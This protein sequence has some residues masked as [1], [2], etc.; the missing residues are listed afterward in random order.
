MSVDSPDEILALLIQA[1]GASEVRA[2]LKRSRPPHRP[3][4][5]GIDDGAALAHMFFLIF[6]GQA[7][8]RTKAARLSTHL[9]TGNSTESTIRRLRDKYNRGVEYVDFTEA[10]LRL[11]DLPDENL[12]WLVN[13][14]QEWNQKQAAEMEIK[15]RTFSP[16]EK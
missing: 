12:Q 8:D 2:G 13:A 16:E 9:T 3:R 15:Y 14:L 7:E 11:V 4:G 1:F 5:S 10:P 6:T